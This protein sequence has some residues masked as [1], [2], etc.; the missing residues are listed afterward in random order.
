MAAPDIFVPTGSVN[1]LP[2]AIGTGSTTLTTTPNVGGTMY[3]VYL[4]VGSTDATN[5]VNVTVSIGGTV[6]AIQ[7]VAAGAGPYCVL[8]GIRLGPNIAVTATAAVVGDAAAII[9]VNQ[10]K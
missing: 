5:G 8:P 1:G 6:F 10:V 3:E 9:N 2:I 4:W 7:K